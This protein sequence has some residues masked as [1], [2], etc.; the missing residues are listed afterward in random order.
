MTRLPR[1]AHHRSPAPA[2]HARRRRAGR[3][4]GAHRRAAHRARQR[5]RH[6]RH[7][8]PSSR[9]TDPRRRSYSATP[10][11]AS[12]A[13][14]TSCGAVGSSPPL[15]LAAHASTAASAP[16]VSRSSARWARSRS[17][18]SAASGP[19][20][21]ATAARQRGEPLLARREQVVGPRPVAAVVP[22]Q[23]GQPD[24]VRVDALGAQLGDEHQVAAA[25]ASSSR[26]RARSCRS[27]R[28]AWR[29]G[30]RRCAPRRARRRTRGAGR[31]G[32]S[33]RR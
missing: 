14:R 21:R 13:S 27:A 16:G 32:P 6:R 30:G 19:V 17:T 23:Q 8:G 15:R 25:L 3:R 9:P 20:P 18:S 11:R 1:Q 29:T 5:G 7:G 33:R 2:R 12:T 24:R 22:G 4:P 10:S 28:S 31:S 26:R